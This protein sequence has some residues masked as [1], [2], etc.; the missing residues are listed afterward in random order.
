MSDITCL[1]IWKA[2]RDTTRIG[3]TLAVYDT[4]TGRFLAD[5]S[6]DNGSASSDGSIAWSADGSKMVTGL[7]LGT[8]LGSTRGARDTGLRIF[9]AGPVSHPTK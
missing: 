7:R 6:I 3:R 1:L 9:E 5:L 8:G 2:H 4:A